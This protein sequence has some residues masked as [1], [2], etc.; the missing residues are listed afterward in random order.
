M[1]GIFSAARQINKESW[2]FTW[3]HKKLVLGLIA[4]PALISFFLTLGLSE[5]DH[6]MWGTQYFYLSM[7]IFTLPWMR[8]ILAS[9]KPTLRSY[10]TWDKAYFVAMAYTIILGGLP[11]FFLEKG[12]SYMGYNPFMGEIV[13]ETIFIYT[14]AF[15]LFA[16]VVG[17]FDFI[18]PSIALDKPFSLGQT[19]RN[20]MSFY[21]QYLISLLLAL[22]RFMFIGILLIIL[23]VIVLIAQ[24]GGL[25]TPSSIHK[26]GHFIILIPTYFWVTYSCT[27][28]TAY[29]KK[30][31]MK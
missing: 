23:V 22:A 16:M 10:F 13:N 12:L 2:A 4:L 14:G 1:S 19:F 7:V 8:Y 26:I 30:H 3:K 28:L 5:E 25:E 31:L 9:H 11:T 24:G 29:Y 27:I 17:P 18:F 20:V 6:F 21:G 15:L